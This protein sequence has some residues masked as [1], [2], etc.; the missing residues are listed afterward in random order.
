MWDRAVFSSLWRGRG[1]LVVIGFPFWLELFWFMRLVHVEPLKLQ[2][3]D[4]LAYPKIMKLQLC[5]FLRNKN[6]S[7]KK[8]YKTT[9]SDV[10]GFWDALWASH[11]LFF[12]STI[13]LLRPDKQ[14]QV[15]FYFWAHNLFCGFHPI[16]LY[17]F[18]WFWKWNKNEIVLS[19]F[20]VDISEIPS[21]VCCWR[22]IFSVLRHFTFICVLSEFKCGC[23]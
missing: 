8:K 4:S 10:L 16:L 18:M 12:P 23:G 7:P 5:S 6:L 17:C 13:V 20:L 3:G 14:A 9:I 1:H 22:G 11:W 19:A 2:S 21:P 15:N